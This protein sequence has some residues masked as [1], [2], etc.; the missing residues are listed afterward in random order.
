MPEDSLKA[1][2]YQ[3]LKRHRW[4]AFTALC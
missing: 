1:I 4:A 3:Y 2:S